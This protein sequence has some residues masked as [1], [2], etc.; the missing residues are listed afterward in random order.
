MSREI[1]GFLKDFLAMRRDLH[2][3][4]I[5]PSTTLPTATGAPPAPKS[6]KQKSTSEVAQESMMGISVAK[7]IEDKPPKKDV[8][9][10]F[11]DQCDRL[12]KEKMK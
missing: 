1:P 6:K 5:P 10:Y 11:Q 4:S 2:K 7:I 8:I 9:Q 3:K 12:T